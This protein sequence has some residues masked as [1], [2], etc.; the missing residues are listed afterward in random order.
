VRGYRRVPFIPLPDPELRDDVV[1]HSLLP[2]DL[3]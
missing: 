3:R 1:T 2:E